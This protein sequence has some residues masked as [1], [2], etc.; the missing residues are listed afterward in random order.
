M[1]RYALRNPWWSL[2]DFHTTKSVSQLQGDAKQVHWQ[3]SAEA[4][5]ASTSQVT[6]FNYKE[7]RTE[8]E[9]R[10]VGKLHSCGH[11]S[12]SLLG[13]A[14]VGHNPNLSVQG[15]GVA[16]SMC[17]PGVIVV[18]LCLRYLIHFLFEQSCS[19]CSGPPA[20][21]CCQ[22]HISYDNNICCVLLQIA[23]DKAAELMDIVAAGEE[24]SSYAAISQQLADAY[25][26]A[27]LKDV[28][29]FIK[30]AS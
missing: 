22:A 28:A 3:L 13:C 24:S 11:H 21:S 2:K 26:Q 15:L 8:E 17:Q 4:T 18:L 27:G 14:A 12:G 1:A 29:N 23:L 6:G 30:A 5:E 20:A 10:D 16:E 7:P 19:C 9:V 25:Q